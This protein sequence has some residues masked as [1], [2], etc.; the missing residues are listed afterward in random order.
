ME[1]LEVELITN[2]WANPPLSILSEASLTWTLEEMLFAPNS[3]NNFCF[4]LR[5]EQAVFGWQTW[6]S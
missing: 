1:E 5:S 3:N 2:P 4:D 6:K